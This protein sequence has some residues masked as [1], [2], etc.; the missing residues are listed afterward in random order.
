MRVILV[1]L[2]AKT[3]N[4]IVLNLRLRW[5]ALEACNANGAQPVHQLC[6]AVP[7]LIVLNATTGGAQAVS[8]IRKSCDAAM[9]V[10]APE[11]EEAE[12]VDMLEA[13]ADDYLG[14]SA[15]PAQLVARV[16]AALRRAQKPMERPESLLECGELQV[17]PDSHEVL[18]KGQVIYLTPT[19]FKLLCHLAKNKGRLVTYQALKTIVWGSEGDFYADSLRKYVQRVRQKIGERGRVGTRIETVPRT[20]YRLMEAAP[21]D[22]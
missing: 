19:E 2:D 11:P 7:D 10:L 3:S 21:G 18:I 5:P 1:G 22:S 8:E 14:L 15:S 9:V 17:N 12:L 20:G 6:S 13:G 16:S 4:S